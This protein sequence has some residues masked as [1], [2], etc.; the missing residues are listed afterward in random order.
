M[1]LLLGTTAAS[2]QDWADKMFKEKTHDFGN[3]AR[4][5]K[6]E[7]YFEL[8][9][10]YQED[11]HIA[12]VRS[13]C[14]CTTPRIE[15]QTLK[16]REKGAIIATFN[17]QSFTGYKAATITVVFDRPFYAE[18]QLTVSGDIRTDVFFN[19]SEADFG[20]VQEGESK[21]LKLSVTRLNNTAWRITDVQSQCADLAMKLSEPRTNSNSVRYDLTLKL[22]GSMPVGEIHEQ[23]NLITNDPAA[24]NVGMCISGVVKPTLVVNPASV[25]MGQ[26]ATGKSFERKLIVRADQPFAITEVVCPDE[27]FRFE[28]PA[29]KKKLH[30]L[31]LKFQAGA[32]PA[33]IAQRI[34]VVSDLPNERYAEVLVTGVVK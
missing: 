15:K 7:H 31:P 2:A 26:V 30:F 1:F 9:N 14:G 17:T 20:T 4:A 24:P 3:V 33:Q 5:A 27:R 19:P 22:K 25:S 23:V 13:S 10:I 16:S 6:V 8:E 34:R 21:Q 18:V 12:S 11:V 32:D 29:G 28:K